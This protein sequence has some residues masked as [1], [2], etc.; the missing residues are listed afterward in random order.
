[1]EAKK[2]TAVLAAT[3]T[4]VGTLLEILSDDND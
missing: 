1:M 2:I 3:V 4:L